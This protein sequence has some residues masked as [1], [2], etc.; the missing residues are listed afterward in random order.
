M[1]IHRKWKKGQATW[2]EYRDVARLCRDEVREAKAQLE[3]DLA[4]DIKKNKKGFY[5]YINQK[6]KV[7][8]NVPPLLSSNGE[9]VSTEEEKAEVL[10]N[11][12]ASVFTGNPSPPSSCID[13]PQVEDPGDKVHPTITEGMVRDRL[14]NLK[15]YKSMGPDE[16]HPRVLKELAD[17]VAKPLSMIFEKSWQ[18]GE[19]PADWKKGN[20]TPIFKKGRK[21][22]PGNY[23]PVSLTSV[24]GKIM[25]Q[26]LLDAMLG[27]MEDRGMI[28][29]SQHGFTRGKSCLT[30]L[31]AFYDEVTRSVDKGRPM[32]VI[33]LDFCKAFDTVPHNIL[34]AKLEGYGFDGWTVRWIRNWLN[35]RTQRVVLNGFKSRWRAV[36]SGVPQGS[37][38]GPVLFNIFI[39]D[40]DRG[41]ESTIS[42]F[43]DDTKLC[44]VVD[45]PEGRYVI[46]RDLDR[47]ERW[48]Q[49]NLMRFNKSKCRIL[50]LGRNNP[51]Y[52]YRLGDEIL[53]SS[54]EER[55]L[56]VLMDEKLDMSRQCALA[57]QKANHILGCIKRSVASRSREVILPLYSA[58][59]RPHLEYCVQVWSPQY[60]KDM[61]LMERVQ[62]RATK[63]I[64]G[65]EHL[66]YEDRL[67]ELGLFSLEKRRL[68]GD[69]I[70]AFQYLRGAYR[71]AG[72]GLFTKAYSDRTR[73]NGFKLEKGRFRLDIR[74]KFFTMRV[75][76]HWNRL[77]REVV[78]APSLEIFK[79][80][81]DEALGNLV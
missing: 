58:L 61:D 9:L 81:L 29:D 40:I 55:D 53:E 56:G 64:R 15:I 80:K 47:L 24:P 21:E 50:H 66:S 33:Y 26:I 67:K 16:I 19:V 49:M 63:M 62:R 37:V 5:R 38:L 27:H 68:R 30:N 45:T 11:F 43:A 46:Q 77:P 28:Q 39:K 75:V 41:I 3:L 32:D 78:E 20:I 73:G 6:R 60:R 48:A 17:E 18:S 74:K 1:G 79:G 34:L 54:P 8:E 31:V 69:L 7:K 25:E 71:K 13:G 23:R 12:F 42:K 14:R 36:T 4:R 72:E 2:E 59:V 22:D 52:K 10:N 76:E 57:A 35:G 44:G 70:A 51:Q 65:L